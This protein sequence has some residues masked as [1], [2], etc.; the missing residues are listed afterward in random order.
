MTKQIMG[1]L[2]YVD[3]DNSD[4]ITEATRNSFRQAVAE[5]IASDNL[6]F[7]NE[8]SKCVVLRKSF[9]SKYGKRAIDIIVSGT[10]LI[11]LA[12]VNIVLGVC[13][14]FDVGRPIF[15]SQERIGKNGKVF[16]IIKFRNMTND[17][18]K[19]GE[20][21]P[22]AQR[23]TKFGKFVR[24]TSLDELLN[25]WCI[26]KGDMSVIGPRPLPIGYKD[27]FSKRHNARH[28]VRPGLE[29]P[30]IKNARFR[31]TWSDQFE[32]DIYYVENLS[33]KLD[34]K[35]LLTLVKMVF[36]KKSSKIRGDSERGTFMG[37]H[38]NGQSI[39]SHKVPIEYVKKAKQLF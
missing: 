27:R 11:V 21:L 32:N 18:D 29:C 25:F 22:P 36:D 8:R 17:C 38:K 16:N 6:K 35:M 10:A 26:F 7:V 30:M 9:Y 34:I 33:L 14:Y 12:P 2:K 3:I 1:L 28:L 31:S 24:K 4:K 39:D 19:N 13:T 37:Y 5:I 20:L 15:F 23:V